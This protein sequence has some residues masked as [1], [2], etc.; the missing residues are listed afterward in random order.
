MQAAFQCVQ[1]R[2]PSGKRRRAYDKSVAE[3]E[4]ERIIADNGVGIPKDTDFRKSGSLGLRLVVILAEGQL[5]GE[6]VLNREEGTEY[7]IRFKRQM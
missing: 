2:V 1:I 5:D 3:D 6:I 4:F 7:R